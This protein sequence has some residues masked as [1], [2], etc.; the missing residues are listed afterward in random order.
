MCI[1]YTVAI[2]VCL[3]VSVSV[4]QCPCV[5]ARLRACPGSVAALRTVAAAGHAGVH[6]RGD[7]GPDALLSPGPEPAVLGR[8][9][10]AGCLRQHAAHL[11]HVN[12]TVLTDK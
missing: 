10:A 7:D 2:N 9:L 12:V 3:C 1:I 4:Y 11:R 6:V 8:V 5:S